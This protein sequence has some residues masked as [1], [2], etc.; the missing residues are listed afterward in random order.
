MIA[1]VTQGC[2]VPT[3]LCSTSERSLSKNELSCTALSCLQ[4]AE[5]QPCFQILLC[6]WRQKETKGRKKKVEGYQK[7]NLTVLGEIF[8]VL[9]E[10]RKKIS[11]GEYV[12]SVLISFCTT[13]AGWEWAMSR[14]KIPLPHSPIVPAPRAFFPIL[15]SFPAWQ[16]ILSSLDLHTENHPS[17]FTITGWF[18]WKN[19]FYW[20]IFTPVLALSNLLSLGA[21]SDSLASLYL[22]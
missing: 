3:W 18:T 15:W 5:T 22:L 6:A 20:A 9:T 1:R 7:R 21:A 19:N 14:R 12:C 17:Y 2:P 4:R 16:F 13:P 10:K 8:S 11:S